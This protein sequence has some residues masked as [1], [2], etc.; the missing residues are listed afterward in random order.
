[1]A[2]AA[3]NRVQALRF[4]DGIPS[5]ALPGDPHGD[6]AAQQR[7]DVQVAVALEGLAALVK[8]ISVEFDDETLGAKQDVD[9]A[10]I[11]EDVQ[12]VGRQLEPPRKRLE[13]AFELRSG[14]GLRSRRRGAG[15]A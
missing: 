6:E 1:M 9:L 13:P 11:Q 15:A 4:G 10:T 8:L 12:L 14:W 7:V 3:K 5:H 2:A